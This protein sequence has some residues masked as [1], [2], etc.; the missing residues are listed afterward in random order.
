MPDRVIFL[1]DGGVFAPPLGTDASLRRLR[2]ETGECAAF[3][4]AYHLE[5]LR[6][7]CRFLEL[8]EPP[9]DAGLA[10]ARR[11]VDY[12]I[13]RIRDGWPPDTTVP[14]LADLPPILPELLKSEG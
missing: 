11:A 10:I 8:P 12:V 9:D 4:R 7:M 3:D 13:P 14:T 1:D 5:W 2:A 6:R